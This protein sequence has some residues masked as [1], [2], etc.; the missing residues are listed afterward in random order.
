MIF[1]PGYRIGWI[2]GD[3]RAIA[4]YV[5]VKQG[6][7]L[8]CS[9]IAQ[10]EISKY[11]ELYDIEKHIEKIRRTYKRRRDVAVQTMEAEFPEGVVFTRPQGGLFSWVE[12]PAHVDARDVLDE[13]LKHNVAFVPGGSFFPNARKENTFRINFS[14]MSEEKINQG[15][16]CL[17]DVLKE[18]M[19]SADELKGSRSR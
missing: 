15:L 19:D 7:D 18:F 12:L 8:Q 5:I 16:T 6:A 3:K 11:L 4:N 1:W 13:C 17:A 14:N 9:T 2:A 10:M